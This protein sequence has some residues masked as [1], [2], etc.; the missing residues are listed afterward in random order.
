MILS[1]LNSYHS[2]KQ[3]SELQYGI[4]E[5]IHFATCY[6]ETKDLYSLVVSRKA[7]SGFLTPSSQGATLVV[8]NMIVLPLLLTLQNFEQQ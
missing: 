5:A 6:I 4:R 3:Y 1:C 8:R 7:V 2:L